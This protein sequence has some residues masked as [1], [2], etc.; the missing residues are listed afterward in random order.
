MKI[1]VFYNLNFGGAKRVVY[2]QVKGLKKRGHTIDIYV[3]NHQEDIFDPYKYSENVYVYEYRE[4]R[5][6]VL[7]KFFSDIQ[8]FTS[9]KQLHKKIAQDIDARKYDLVLA[10]PDRFTQSPFLLRFVKTKSAY[11]C[12]EPLRI[13]YEYSMRFKDNVIFLKKWYEE[14]TRW[15]RKKIDRDNVRSASFTIASCFHVRERMI[16]SYDVYPSIAYPGIDNTIFRP[17]RVKKTNTV[18]F[19]G[20]KDVF[21]DG[22]DLA[23]KAVNLIPSKIRPKLHVIS[24]KKTNKERLTEDE[25]IRIYNSSIVVLCM[26]RLETFG[27]VPLEAMACGV[28]VIATNV[29][30]HRE[31]VADG[32]AGYLV[33]FDPQ[34]IAEKIINIMQHKEQSAKL[35]EFGVEHIKKKWTWEISND[36]FEKLLQ[37]F[38]NT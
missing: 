33:E 4:K 18:V 14:S 20:G 6:P 32:K 5:L 21:T 28:P 31:T 16:E 25:L 37:K 10:H 29:S 34:E 2:E 38:L 22:Y 36:S 26:S 1:A 3:L 17:I 7:N 9:L 13:A 35:G 8:T 19:V 23:L 27:L 15:I 30:G 12:Q 24:W 11:Y